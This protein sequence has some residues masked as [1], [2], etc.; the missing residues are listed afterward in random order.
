MYYNKMMKPHTFV[1]VCT[2]GWKSCDRSLILKFCVG[3]QVIAKPVNQ[4]K[5]SKHILL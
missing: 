4:N 2:Q 1:P 5:L 3:M